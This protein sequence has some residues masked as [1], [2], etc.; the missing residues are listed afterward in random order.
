MSSVSSFA[1]HRANYLWYN[2]LLYVNY[3]PRVSSKFEFYVS[4]FM[5]QKRKTTR[6]EKIF[7]ILSLLLV[8]SMVLGLVA[9][10]IVR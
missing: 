7:N 6:N 9:V 3:P 10:A 5:S 1:A 2:L 4:Q 8:I